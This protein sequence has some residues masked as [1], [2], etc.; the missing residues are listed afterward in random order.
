M[1]EL[2]KP[3]GTAIFV[4][5]ECREC[6]GLVKEIERLHEA[7]SRAEETEAAWERSR[8]LV[9]EQY[10]VVANALSRTEAWKREALEVESEWDAQAVAKL[11]GL[12]P[13]DSIRAEALREAAEIANKAKGEMGP[14]TATNIAAAILAR[15]QEKNDA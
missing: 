7:L 11:I 13:G 10:R 12:L 6:L 15:I 4:N 2:P 8:D 9:T 14:L 1:I 3:W 5:P